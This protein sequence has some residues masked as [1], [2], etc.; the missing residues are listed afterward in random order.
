MGGFYYGRVALAAKYVTGQPCR[1]FPVELS[2]VA[3][4]SAQHDDV[5]VNHVDYGGQAAGQ[6]FQVL[7]QGFAGFRV[8]IAGGFGD[9]VGG[10]L[11]AGTQLVGEC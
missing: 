2:G 4:A 7:V 6:V 5:G 11:V 8:A 3:H 1:K 9:G 10:L